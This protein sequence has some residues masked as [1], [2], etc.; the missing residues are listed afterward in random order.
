MGVD[1]LPIDM[2]IGLDTSLS[3]DF[4]DKWINVRDALKLFVGN[5]KYTD[6]GVG[7]QF[8]PIRKQC[9]VDAYQT[10]AVP[11]QLQAQAAG[12]IIAALDAQEMA[13][14]TPMVPLLEGL[15]GYLHT[16]GTTNRKQVL[17][18]ATDGFPDDN[19]LD[20]DNGQVLANTFDNAIAVAKTAFNGT[21]SIPTFV[22]GVGTE[23]TALNDVAAAGGT[24]AATIVDTS[25]G[26][27]TQ[28]AFVAALDNIRKR[29]IPCD[30][31]IPSGPID[32]NA[33]NVTYT[34]GSGPSEQLVFVG[35]DTDCTKAPDNG[36]YFDNEAN[37]TE[38]ILC[39]AT[40]NIVK[41]DDLGKVS[42]VFGCPRIDVK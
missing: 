33:T 20:T 15:Y 12:P 11:L 2:M 37:P 42:L 21:P 4:D 36:W 19:C 24:T 13:G 28:A 8:F 7:L 39:D 14:G 32:V 34:P 26:S 35:S 18:L 29:A 17:V 23:L 41:E 38:V 31:A 10:P 25:S 22:I 16:T 1:N 30:F 27:D 6:L 9:N 5:P 40:C 3:M